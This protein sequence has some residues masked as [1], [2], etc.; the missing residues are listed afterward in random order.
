MVEHV[1]ELLRERGIRP[2][3]HRV[4][5]GRPVLSCRNHPTANEV[6]EAV[7]KRLPQ[8][9]RATV[10]NTLALFVE[11]GLLLRLTFLDGPAFYDPNL[12]PHHHLMDEV[13]GTIHDIP[14][15]SIKLPQIDSVEGFELTEYQLV[16]RGRRITK[17]GGDR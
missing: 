2:S 1:V 3:A 14:W 15:E 5:V 6:W 10:Y 8:L 16:L 12:N 9:S 11:K 7:S 13:T 4:A 17:Q